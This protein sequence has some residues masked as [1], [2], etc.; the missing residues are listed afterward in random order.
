MICSPYFVCN[1]AHEETSLIQ[2]RDH[3][4]LLHLYQITDDLVIEI[5]NL[6][7]HMYVT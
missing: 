6:Q 2:E 3:S 4:I 7:N 1:S 5:V